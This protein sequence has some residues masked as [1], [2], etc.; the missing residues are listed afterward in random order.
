MLLNNKLIAAGV[1]VS[2][3]NDFSLHTQQKLFKK[4]DEIILQEKVPVVQMVRIQ[5]Y[6]S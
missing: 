1:I 3:C 2:L 4:P 6:K 5:C